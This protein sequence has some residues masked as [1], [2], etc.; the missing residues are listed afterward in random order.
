VTS[1]LFSVQNKAHMGGR[2]RDPAPHASLLTPL[3]LRP[4]QPRLKYW[5]FL[6]AIALIVFT[7]IIGSFVASWLHLAPADQALVGNLAEQLLPFPFIGGV[8]LLMI[9]GGLVS[10]LF[11][12]YII[13][14]LQLGEETKLISLSNPDYR[15]VPRGAK[16]IIQLT[17]ILNEFGQEFKRLRTEVDA[18]IR[19]AKAQLKDERNRLAV[20]MSQL[21][22]GVLVCNADGLILLYNDQAKHL[23]QQPGRLIGLGRSLF[24]VLDREPI[25][26]ALDLLHQAT[27][28]GETKPRTSFMM[29]PHEGLSLKF[30][31][32]PIFSDDAQDLAIT[33]FV[34]TVDDMTQQIEVELQRDLMFQT[35]T[36]A[37]RFSTGE[38]R[39]AISTILGTPN[40]SPT[41]LAE[42][43]Q[44]IDR[45]SLAME[46]Q[47][48]FAK[49]DYAR[50]QYVQTR[51][52]NV[53]GDYLL[54][55]LRKHLVRRQQFAVETRT[56]PDLW[57]KINS[58]T[59]VQGLVQLG[60]CLKSAGMHSIF[61]EL[62]RQSEDQAQLSITWPGCLLDKGL[63]LEWQRRPLL[64][65]ANNRLVS[66][67]EM[68]EQHHGA[69]HIVES[70]ERCQSLQISLPLTEPDRH[71][72][73]PSR[74]Q[75][76]P[77]YYEFDLFNQAGWGELGKVP[78]SK[79]TFV[80]FDTET[81]GL[82]P[83]DGDE[84]I[85]LGAI[86]IVNGRILYNETIDQLVDP[87]RYVPIASIS[88]HGI[89]PELLK[90]Q[91]TIE[92]VL[93]T[94]HHFAEGAVLV[95][96]N[97]AFDMKF[98]QRGG[99]ACGLQFDH[100]VLD[101]LLLSSMVHPHQEKHSLDEVARRLQIPI[102]GRHTALG[103][104]IVT[105]E[106][107]VRLLPLLEAQG[108]LTLEDA[109]QVSAASPYA[110]L[111]Y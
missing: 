29:R 11:H 15:I 97:A 31:M 3:G 9:I 94:F 58:F 80:V 12:Y 84:I 46:S 53:L 7:V 28:Q 78:L 26:H 23:L 34:L 49:A 21:P 51:T 19:Q 85:Q 25:I 2:E 110:K 47:V 89:A 30:T 95:A 16:E 103:D 99:E 69:V 1:P 76:R 55:L 75:H 98:L 101:T 74:P 8:L 50:Y 79:L 83:S 60:E 106:V 81:T 111:I 73:H 109:I 40:L 48:Q 108:I 6:L 4:M 88:I 14:I 45:A 96:H 56:A 90:G 86:R 39:Q 54:E 63:L 61:L 87:R 33:G 24:G 68:V 71:W 82:N 66:F 5:F 37:M 104:A 27:R 32:K 38:I 91:P 35:L 43:R 18:Q 65:D 64:H 102:I 36:E 100:P 67:L 13:P 41:E 22:N 70:Q 107:L 93:P 10:L 52:E 17:S 92:Q 44:T 72:H 105:A 62:D 20:L 77:I 42:H 57:L 59:L